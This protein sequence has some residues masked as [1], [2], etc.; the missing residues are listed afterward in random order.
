[1]DGKYL[2]T[3]V[4]LARGRSRAVQVGSGAARLVALRELAAAASAWHVTP[5]CDRPV[6]AITTARKP[7]DL[8][9]GRVRTALARIVWPWAARAPESG[10]VMLS[11]A[12]ADTVWQAL[13]DAGAWHGV[14]GD[15]AAC[16]ASGLC[17]GKERHEVIAVQY[18]ALRAWMEG[19]RR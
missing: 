8:R 10:A 2:E 13:A 6:A 15:C 19:V 11:A 7:G 9:A 5:V 17:A 16:V 18:A 12:D 3:P 1:M 4:G 14:Y